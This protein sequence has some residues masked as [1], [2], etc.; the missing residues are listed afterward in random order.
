MGDVIRLDGVG[1]VRTASG[2][3]SRHKGQAVAI[4]LVLLISAA[5]GPLGLAGARQQDHRHRRAG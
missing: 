3:M 4:G 5:L 1:A 2:G